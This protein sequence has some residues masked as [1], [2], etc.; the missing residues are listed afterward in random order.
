MLNLLKCIFVFYCRYIKTGNTVSLIG[1]FIKQNDD[2]LMIVEPQEI[3]STGC[4]WQRLLL[5]SEYDGL[6]LG[7]PKVPQI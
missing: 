4:A 3:I 1:M 5:P 6:I 2:V 7:P